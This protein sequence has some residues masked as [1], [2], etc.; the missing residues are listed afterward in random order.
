[1]AYHPGKP[2]RIPQGRAQQLDKVHRAKD[3]V[4]ITA[5]SR[6]AMVLER[7]A[8]EIIDHW[9]RTGHW[10]QPSL[11]GADLVTERF[12]RDV[13]TEAWHATE[14]EKRN[15]G[16]RRRLASAPPKPP[17]NARGLHDIFAN[18]K[19]WRSVMRRSGSL[20][21]RLRKQYLEKLRRKF[22]QVVPLLHSGEAS[23]EDAKKMMRES[24]DTTRSRVETIFRTETTNYFAQSQVEFFKDEPEIIGFL[25]DSVRDTARTEIC[26]S[27][28]G[29][30][31]RPGTKALRENTPALHYNCRSHLI[32]LANT[33]ANRKLV[34]DE[35]RN[36]E[37]RNVAPLPPGW[38]K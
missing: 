2:F 20:S 9:L 13:V 15:G 36:P 29:L 4:V 17:K 34:E 16:D 24:W 19:Y 21:A 28:H 33:P 27:R 11:H 8:T 30:V 32:A 31:Y 25:F 38:R 22:Q 23:P 37:N 10:V 14:A 12:Y 5:V 7:A 18:S 1:M 3:R 35:D 6:M 26:K